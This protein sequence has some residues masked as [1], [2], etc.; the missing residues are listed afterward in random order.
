[1]QSAWR[2]ESPV[3]EIVRLLQRL[4]ARDEESAQLRDVYKRQAPASDA[5]RASAVSGSTGKLS[6]VSGDVFAPV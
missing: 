3:S 1:M 4:I 5:R 6:P 2:G